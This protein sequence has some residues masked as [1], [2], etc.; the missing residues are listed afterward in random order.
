MNKQ[1]TLVPNTIGQKQCSTEKARL[2]GSRLVLARIAWVALMMLIIAFLF[3][4][5]PVYFEQLHTVC[6]RSLCAHWELTPANAH[7]LQQVGLSI[8][9]YA[10]FN[11]MLSLISVC[12]WFSVAAL[13][14]C[15]KFN[16]RMT[17]L[18]SLLLVTQ[19]VLQLSGSPATP[20]EYGSSAWH[21]PSVTLLLLDIVLYLLVFSIFP[22]GHFAPRWL[23]W[24]VTA[25]IAFA[26][27]LAYFPTPSLNTDTRVTPLTALLT[28]SL[29]ASIIAAQIYR[30]QRVSNPVERQQTRWV[31][32]GIIAGPLLGVVYYFPLLLFPSPGNAGSLYFFLCKPIFTIVFLSVPLCFGIAILRY[33]LWDIDLLINRTLVYGVLSVALALVY[34][35]VVIALQFLLQGLM[36]ANQLAIAGSTLVSA[37]LFHPLRR[38]IQQIIDRRF[39]RSKY[40]AARTLAKFGAT[41]YNEVDLNQ[42]NEQLVTVVQETMQPTHVWLWLRQPVRKEKADR[43]M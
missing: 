22:N 8:N 13:I 10:V 3:A 25:E 17:L 6:T 15:R 14:V 16:D 29:Y 24:L 42:L 4:N 28:F 30:Y 35:G 39:Y 26:A 32:L 34:F 31:V 43:G 18:V 40:D 21:F 27:I 7:A 12:V 9:T 33:R 36:E 11:L 5:I 38:H 23:H 20:L 37:A 2:F 41:L 19:G 1:L